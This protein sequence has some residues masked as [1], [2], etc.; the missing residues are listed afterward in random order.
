VTTRSC[1]SCQNPTNGDDVRCASCQRAQ[2]TAALSPK[3]QRLS[4]Q[5]IARTPWCALCGRNDDLTTDYVAGSGI[6]V[7]CGTCSSGR[8]RA[9]R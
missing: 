7:L 8:Q 4:R 3:W 5:A 1:L 6:R 9:T 2:R